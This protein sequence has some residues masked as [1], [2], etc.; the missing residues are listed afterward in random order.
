MIPECIS[1]ERRYSAVHELNHGHHKY[2]E[3]P[4]MF[5]ASQFRIALCVGVVFSL[6]F[7]F[8]NG[9]GKEIERV[10]GGGEG[11]LKEREEEKYPNKFGLVWIGFTSEWY[12]LL[13]TNNRS[14]RNDR[15]MCRIICPKKWSKF[16]LWSN[17]SQPNAKILKSNEMNSFHY[18]KEIRK[19]WPFFP[20]VDD[21]CI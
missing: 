13:V 4:K 14:I 2:V 10:N 15:S 8:G 18:S 17:A 7:Y 19:K 6:L 3:N 1:V 12:Q 20:V 21:C 16:L 5:H 9:N 11:R